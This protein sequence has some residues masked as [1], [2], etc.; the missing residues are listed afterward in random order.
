MDEVDPGN[1]SWELIDGFIRRIDRGP[2]TDTNR[3]VNP[4]H[5]HTVKQIGRLFAR[6]DGTGSTLRTESDV[7]LSEMHSP[8]PRRLYRRR[9]GRRLRKPASDSG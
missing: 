2:S 4:G 1:R 7:A 9:A 3:T 8:H 6:F 5:A